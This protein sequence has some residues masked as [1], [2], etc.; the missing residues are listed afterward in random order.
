MNKV[1]ARV[2]P[3]NALG[4]DRSNVSLESL[5]GTH[6]CVQREATSR[7]V[8]PQASRLV[9]CALSS[10]GQLLDSQTR[11]F[12][13]P[14]FE[15]DFSKVRVHTDASAAAS[16]RA[17]N[18]NA[19]AIGPHLVFASGRYSPRTAAGQRLLAHELTHVVQQ[20]RGGGSSPQLSKWVSDSGDA[21]EREAVATADRVMKGDPIRVTHT[22][23]ALMQGDGLATGIGVG[24]GAVG[25]GFGIAALAGAFS[26]KDPTVDRIDVVDSPA[27]A[28]NGFDPITSGNLDTPGPWNDPVGGGVSSVLQIHF[29]L[30]KGDS[31]TLTP[32][33]E[34]QRSAWVA[35]IESKNPPD[36]PLPPGVAGPPTPGGFKGV[37]VGPDGPAPHEV[38]RP[39]GDKIVVADAPGAAAL[40]AAQ[41]PFKYQSHFRVTVANSKGADVASAAYD[42]EIEKKSAADVPNTTNSVTSVEKKDI[43]RGKTL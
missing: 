1:A 26:S 19:Y 34:L 33:R 39:S 7:G 32:R 23:D 41:F 2:H 21:S 31:S 35:G 12:M 38:K 42:V 37:I 13:E 15:Q 4:T 16:A 20:D 36:K 25:L 18:A 14:R 10:T 17:M 27:G 6:V 11:A 22:S 24:L 28:A 29:H 30:D 9:R 5:L 40:T 8:D 3:A 43:I